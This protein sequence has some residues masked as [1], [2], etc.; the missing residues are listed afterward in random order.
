MYKVNDTVIYGTQGVCKIIEIA[1][2]DFMGKKKEYYVLTPINNASTTLF[3]PTDNE[4]V[5]AKL[6][7]ILSKEEIHVLV[8]TMNNE[9]PVWIADEKE[10]REKFREIIA[11]G[12]HSA[13]IQMIKAIWIQKQKREAEGKKLHMSDERFFKDAEQLLY[14]EFQYVLE[15]NKEQLIS[16]IFK[17]K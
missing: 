3:A 1:E 13:L 4:A 7:R 8:N 6:R 5:L 12:E 17:T 9:E 15:I 11:S 10:R 14:D 2:K 16:Y